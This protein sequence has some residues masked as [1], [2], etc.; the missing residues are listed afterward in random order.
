[1]RRLWGNS[2]RRR[3]WLLHALR[4]SAGGGDGSGLERGRRGGGARAPDDVAA[5]R[6][7][8][9]CV[10]DLRD[11]R[12]RRRSRH[13]AGRAR[14]AGDPRSALGDRRR[15][16]GAAEAPRRARLPRSARAWA[17][18]AAGLGRAVGAARV[19]AQA[20]RRGA[21]RDADAGG[22]GS[23]GLLDLAEAAEHIGYSFYPAPRDLLLHCDGKVAVAR[24]RGAQRGRR[25]DARR[26]LESLGTC[27]WRRRSSGRRRSCAC[28]C[29]TATPRRRPIAPSTTCGASSTK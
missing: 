28:S 22:G 23:R 11:G 8:G 29:P 24:V 16:R 6:A 17:E 15:D 27:S 19:D 9:G 13:E 12:A 10:H 26:L 4:S 7:Q 25:I 20:R 1:M 2:R 21:E 5:G 14:G 3:R 18:A